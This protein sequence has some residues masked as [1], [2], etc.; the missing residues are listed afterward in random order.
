MAGRGALLGEI[1]R[2]KQLRKAVTN[3]RSAPSVSGGPVGGAS[4]G[5]GTSRPSAGA[6]P[7]PS[8]SSAGAAPSEPPVGNPMLAGLFAGG[9]PKLKSRGGIVTGG[10]FINS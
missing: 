6:P 7:I 4:S 10:I 9:M 3:D 8:S 1:Q 2:G 5:A